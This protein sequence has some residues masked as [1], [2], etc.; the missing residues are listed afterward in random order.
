MMYPYQTR[1][2]RIFERDGKFYPQQY[3]ST[4]AQ[5]CNGLIMRDRKIDIAC[6]DTE[7]QAR[8]DKKVFW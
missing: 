3:S 8:T 2:F 7:E 6:F 4:I 5:W 1:A